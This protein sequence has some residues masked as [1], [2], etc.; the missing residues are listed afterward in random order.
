MVFAIKPIKTLAR[1]K[2]IS[3]QQRILL[4]EEFVRYHQN[5]YSGYVN[6]NWL[7]WIAPKK[8]SG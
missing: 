1:L 5:N 4:R 3:L 7:H 8:F 2:F 6:T